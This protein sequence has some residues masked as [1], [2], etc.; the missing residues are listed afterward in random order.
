M[1]RQEIQQVKGSE[2]KG[3][4]ESSGLCV[5]LHEAANTLLGLGM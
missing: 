2:R 5:Q 3:P 1:D 4:T